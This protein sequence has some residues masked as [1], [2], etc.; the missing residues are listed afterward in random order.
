MSTIKI[1]FAGK[2]YSIFR[3]CLGILSIALLF[4]FFVSCDVVD[5]NKKYDP[6]IIDPIGGMPAPYLDVSVSADGQKL[7]FFRTKY[8][9]VSKD[10]LNIQYDPDSTGIWICNIDGT[11][12]KLIYKNNRD[13]IGRPQFIP[14]SNYILFNLNNQIVKAPY[15]GSLIDSSEI[16]FLTTSGNNFFPSVNFNG[17]LITYDSNS[18][19]PN[20]MNFIWRMKIDGSQKIRIAY[21]PKEGEIRMPYF[22]PVS[23]KITHIRW[24]GVGFPEIFLIDKDGN[25]KV[26]ITNNSYED[27]E[28]RLNYLENRLILLRNGS[29]IIT[30]ISINNETVLIQKSA[31]SAIWNAGNKIIFIWLLGYYQNNGTIWIMNEDGSDKKQITYNYGLVLE[32]G[33]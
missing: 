25:N 20:G 16:E 4:L 9:Y 1:F 5:N 11:E 17:S 8:T 14:N 30:D 3:I 21:E 24:V 26:R 18:D 23:N 19:S 12:M 7:I 22:S 6:P 27:Y 13:F 2:Y 32:G 10:G 31:Q 33:G 15:Y 28:P 29:L